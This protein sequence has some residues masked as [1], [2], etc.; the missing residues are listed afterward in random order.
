MPLLA[1]VAKLIPHSVEATVF[2]FFTGIN[3][4]NQ[5]VISKLIGNMIN[6]YFKVDKDSLGN[7]WK[8]FVV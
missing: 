3:I 5:F 1:T 7:L 4:L 2:A 8:L 6:L